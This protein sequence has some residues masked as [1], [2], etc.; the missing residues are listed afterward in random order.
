M[1]IKVGKTNI[2]YRSNVD[3][4][5]IFSEIVDSQLSYENP[6]LVRTKDE[7]DIWF[8][9]NFA[10][11]NYFNELLK[12]GVTLYL[13]K[14]IEENNTKDIDD[15]IDIETYYIFPEIFL[16]LPQQGESGYAYY[17]NT[18][19]NIKHYYTFGRNS[20]NI[21]TWIPVSSLDGYSVYDNE[22]YSIY[23]LPTSGRV[24]TVYYVKNIPSYRLWYI[25]ENGEWRELSSQE[26]LNTYTPYRNLFSIDSSLPES[27]IFKYKVLSDKSWYVWRNDTWEKTIEDDMQ[28]FPIYFDTPDTLPTIGDNYRYYVSGTWYIWLADSWTSEDIFPQNLDNMSGSLN[29]RDTLMISKPDNE[30]SQE[31]HTPYSYPEFRL[32]EDNHLGIFS[33][34]YDIDFSN[35]ITLDKS[36]L[37]YVDIGYK[38][39]AF[40]LSYT[41]E[42]LDSGYII[43]K[44]QIPDSSGSLRNYCFYSIDDPTDLSA[45]YYY[46]ARTKIDTVQDLLDQY[47]RLGYKVSK[48]GDE[49]YLIY[50]GNIFDFT[51]FYT[52][53][54]IKLTNSFDNTENILTG[55]IQKNKGIEFYSKTIGT[56]YED[57]E[58]N[59]ESLISVKIENTEY[60]KCRITLGRYDYTEVFEGSL[61]TNIGEDRID[62]VI[63]KTSKLVT[64]D[65]SGLKNSVKTKIYSDK[66]GSSHCI[67]CS[68]FIGYFNIYKIHYYVPEIG[69][70]GIKYKVFDGLWKTWDED[71]E[72]YKEITRMSYNFYNLQEEILNYPDIESLQDEIGRSSEFKYFVESENKWFL[73]KDNNWTPLIK[74]LLPSD[75]YSIKIERR[76]YEYYDIFILAGNFS[77]TFSGNLFELQDII[78]NSSEIFVDF[79]FKDL[80]NQLREGEYYLRRGKNE[81][82]TKDMYIRSL[83]C[84]FDTQI[85]NTWPDFFL[86]P[87]IKKYINSLGEIADVEENV[88]LN[89][90]KDLNCQFLIQN[91]D[92]EYKLVNIKLDLG[93]DDFND[94]KDPEEHILYSNEHGTEYRIYSDGS[95]QIFTDRDVIEESIC[96]GD[97]IFNYLE[98]DSNYLVYFYRPMTIFGR[99]RPAYYTFVSSLI[100][101][102]QSFTETLINYDSP[103]ESDPYEIDP[104]SISE[105]LE[106]HKSNFLIN[107]NHEYYYK[108]Y[109]NGPDYYTT[110][111]MR[112]VLGKIYREIQK[113]RWT[114]L[115]QKSVS[116]AETEIKNTLARI[117]NRFSIVSLIILTSIT[118]N[119]TKN[120]L[121]LTI[122]TYVNDLMDNNMTLDITVNYN[123]FN[124]D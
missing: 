114:Y 71:E 69:E 30:D 81:K 106:E 20:D 77:E 90:A 6:T 95:L 16:D 45:V 110:I 51:E 116:I 98:D 78:N 29:N 102:K 15:Y 36:D 87:D 43:I 50:S 12:S 63:N 92:P 70:P 122:D 19:D 7:L 42:E 85:E 83:G 111:W 22:F 113:G 105:D 112:F 4:F 49:E 62:N 18:V 24:G 59:K 79:R 117:Q 40:K 84:L 94:I 123:E 80:C 68:D 25:F 33:R 118:P 104:Q 56:S 54:N 53:S 124:T 47:V 67:D 35:D 41:S 3:D 44:S 86:V 97:F 61:F 99:P 72:R 2:K 88:F 60:E 89:H 48:T 23:D 55:Y 17:L 34:S 1:Y 31:F 76:D 13:Y 101:N 27:G 115:S 66:I 32:F 74:E 91:N 75:R 82:Q 120:Y 38:T 5:M 64:C 9:R 103:L 109:F 39:M 52:Y 121:E 8:G 28:E 73:W 10:S 11:R 108:K 21:Y 58:N 37:N 100:N 46:G 93:I 119:L 65:I 107:N 96:G 57:S 14:P 26:E